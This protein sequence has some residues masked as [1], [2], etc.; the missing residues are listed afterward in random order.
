MSD[1][2]RDSRLA[3]GYVLWYIQAVRGV[4]ELGWPIACKDSNS[5]WWP[6]TTMSIHCLNPKEV[7]LTGGQ[8][9]TGCPDL[10]RT[11]VHLE[12]LLIT[13]IK[14]KGNSAFKNINLNDR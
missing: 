1:C 13:F 5:G 3:N 6:F 14:R 7:L 9:S 12:A 4:G 10:P 8:R 11:M 2:C